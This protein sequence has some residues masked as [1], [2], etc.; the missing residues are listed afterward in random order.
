MILTRH[1]HERAAC[2]AMVDTYRA[3]SAVREVGKALGLPEVEVGVVAK[4]FPHISA[5]HLREGLERLPELQGLQ[6]PMRQLD[7]LFRVAERLD[8]FPRHIAL[9][10]CGI[11]LAS[12]DLV[13]RVPL[14]RSAGGHRMIQADKDDVEALGYLKLDILG[15]RMLSSMRHAIEEIA[16]TT[17][18]K[19]DLDRIALDDEPTFELIRASDTLGCFQIESPGQRELIGKFSPDSFADLIIDISLFRPG[20]VKTDMV[21]PFLESRQGWSEA[22]Y[23]H[24]DLE[25]VLAETYGVVVFHEQVLRI[26]A[27]CTGCSLAEADEDAELRLPGCPALSPQSWRLSTSCSSKS[28]PRSRFSRTCSLTSTGDTILS[29]IVWPGSR[30]PQLPLPSWILPTA[31]PS[32]TTSTS[33]LRSICFSPRATFIRQP[34]GR[35]APECSGT[36]SV[37]RFE[38]CGKTSANRTP[39]TVFPWTR[40]DAGRPNFVAAW[41]TLPMGTQRIR[42]KIL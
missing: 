4:A 20:P 33:A 26:V 28:S 6:L 16:R 25:A 40:F 5:R 11:V 30:P 24:P 34:G 18:Q 13:Q 37:N 32:S 15:V 12:H 27:I 23:L 31:R 10:P 39:I 36:L 42:S 8:G 14:E 19:V 41:M 35:G 9:H 2:V 1:G 38:A 7:L 22:S 17:G 21:R 3:R 29:M